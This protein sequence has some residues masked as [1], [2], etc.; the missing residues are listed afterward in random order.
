MPEPGAQPIPG[1]S[2]GK[3]KGFATLASANPSSAVV[4]GT[5]SALWKRPLIFEFLVHY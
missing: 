2:L 5:R 1:C 3:G 4:A